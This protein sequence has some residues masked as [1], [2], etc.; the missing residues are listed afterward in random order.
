MLL[1]QG[2]SIRKRNRP[3][4][5]SS[6]VKDAEKE[7]TASVGEKKTESSDRD[8]EMKVLDE[9][10]D[11]EQFDPPSVCDMEQPPSLEEAVACFDEQV[12]DVESN[13]EKSQDN[14]V[15]SELPAPSND[16][17]NIVEDLSVCR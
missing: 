16:G 3:S 4:T 14:I 11:L 15:S 7:G 5:S 9:S 10:M 17:N 2:K 8:V 13:E 1:L 12:D 6:A